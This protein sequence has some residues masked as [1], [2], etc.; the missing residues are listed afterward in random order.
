MV[1]MY[2]NMVRL[3][4]EVQTMYMS[5]PGQVNSHDAFRELHFRKG[6]APYSVPETCTHFYNRHWIKPKKQ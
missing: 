5:L 1:Q 2:R 3:V 4:G 6:I